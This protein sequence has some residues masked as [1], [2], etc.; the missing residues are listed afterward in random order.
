[1]DAAVR[2]S[3]GRATHG[4]VAEHKPVEKCWLASLCRLATLAIVLI[5]TA[6]SIP[7]PPANRYQSDIEVSQLE[8]QPVAELQSQALAALDDANYQ[9]AIDY[10]QRAIKIQPRNA[11]SWHYLAQTYW[12]KGQ[13]ERCLS[14]IER[15]GSYANDD[16]VSGANDQLRTQCQQG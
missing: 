1:M 8:A 12:R 7:E 4:A 10:L 16:V 3:G 11:W 9:Q 13:L 6:C 15:S 14:M 5:T 2:R